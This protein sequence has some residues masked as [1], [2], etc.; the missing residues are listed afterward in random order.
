[1]KHYK[2]KLSEFVNHE[3]THNE[4][5]KVGEHLLLCADCRAEHDQIRF[6]ENLA[7]QLKQ[8]DAPANLW[9]KIEN[10]LDEKAEKG[11]TFSHFAFIG[12]PVIAVGFLIV[13]GLITTAIYLGIWKNDSNETVKNE[14]RKTN[15]EIPQPVSAP[16][17]T[18]IN[19]NTNQT[20]EESAAVQPILK[21]ETQN[22]PQIADSNIKSLPKNSL[23]LPKK[24]LP[25]QANLPS[26]EVETLAGTPKIGDSF[27]SE[28][29]AVGE[30][31]E[32]DKNSRARVQVADIG[33]VE[34]APNSRVKLV[35]TKSTE[36]RLSLEKGELHA[37]IFAPPRLFIVDTPS[38]VAVDL[39]CEYT[40]EVDEKGDSKLRVTGGFVALENGKVS[41]IVPAGAAA[42]TKKEKGIGTPFADSSTVELQNALYKFDFENG[43]SEALEIILKESDLYDALTLWHLL[44]KTQ[45]AER[46]KV[47]DAL[48]NKIAPPANV[49]RE[50]ILKLNKKMLDA[51]WQE[52][53]NVWFE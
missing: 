20:S 9:H 37:K 3:L 43:G 23:D 25:V 26:W 47:F 31:L 22:K 11:A 13:F 15:I 14:T 42:L 8:T 38:A 48:K 49:T 29:L 5:Q 4:R 18:I 46:E 40:L 45:K 27:K 33:N 1:M 50:G 24:T 32:T 41:S 2:E 51:W 10:S 28:K 30:F 19:Q 53:E 44:P 36:H 35:K 6:G 34:I 16:N 7:A 52:I 39:G 21:T 17:E 12:S